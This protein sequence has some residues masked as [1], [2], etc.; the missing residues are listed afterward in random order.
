MSDTYTC[1]RCGRVSYNPHDR[2]HHYCGACKSFE[3]APIG[4]PPLSLDPNDPLWWLELGAEP[5][6]MQLIATEHLWRVSSPRFV[7]GVIVDA[8]A[9]I[10]RAAPILRK[11]QGL[12]LPEL[13]LVADTLG[14]QLTRLS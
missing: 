3:P 14:W 12:T 13:E 6:W 2:A 11:W 4:T 5:D 7:A 10:R 1:P 8:Q 9:R